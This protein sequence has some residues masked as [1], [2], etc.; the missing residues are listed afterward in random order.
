MPSPKS[1]GQVSSLLL[2]ALLVTLGKSH[3]LAVTFFPI[4]KV[5]IILSSSPSGVLPIRLKSVMIFFITSKGA[6]PSTVVDPWNQEVPEHI[7]TW[8]WVVPHKAS[9]RVTSHGE[10]A[11]GMP[12][13]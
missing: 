13:R 11:F 8:M 9:A 3:H 6:V 10:A 2:C 4:S 7:E 1:R 12:G 5:L